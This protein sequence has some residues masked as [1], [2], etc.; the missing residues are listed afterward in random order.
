M[1]QLLWKNSRFPKN[2]GNSTKEVSKLLNCCYYYDHVRQEYIKTDFKK[3]L[4]L[5]KADPAEFIR[6]RKNLYRRDDGKI[7]MVMVK[8]GMYHGFRRKGIPGGNISDYSRGEKESLTHQGNKEVIADLKEVI[9]KF[10]NEEVKIFVEYAE[11]EKTVNCNGRRYEIDIYLK[12]KNTEPEC[13]FEKW[14]GELWFEIFHTC[15]VDYQQAEDFAIANKTLFEYKVYDYYNFYD[16]ISEEGYEK[17]KSMISRMYSAKG[18]DGMLICQSRN[19]PIHKWK[20]STNG[21]MTAYIGDSN[22][23][24]VKSKYGNNYGIGY[25]NGK[26]KWKYNKKKFNSEEDAMK[27][28]EYFAFLLFNEGKVGD[29]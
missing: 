18:I 26:W 25:G 8:E 27:V 24:I 28:A 13:Y 10:G 1:L 19:M 9:L 16:N 23:T 17:R 15:K 22:F 11:C 20:R 14:N 6:R 3:M 5:E 2:K 4:Q 21:N 29:L 12:L 7:P